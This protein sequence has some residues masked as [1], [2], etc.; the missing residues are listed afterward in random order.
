MTEVNTILQSGHQHIIGIS[1]SRF[2][3]TQ[4]H[5]GHESAPWKVAT[6]LQLSFLLYHMRGSLI[7]SFVAF[8]LYLDSDS[9]GSLSHYLLYCPYTEEIR[10][11]YVPK[12]IVDNP[13]AARPAGNEA[14]LM[15]SILDPE[16]SR[17]PEEIRY[18]WE[19]ITRIYFLSRDYVYNVHNKFEKFYDVKSWRMNSEQW[20][21]IYLT[22]VNMLLTEMPFVNFA[23]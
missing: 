3:F 13:K 21:L 18:N 9:I 12:F 17:L 8:A 4:L 20:D 6:K 15:M 2:L 16:S 5:S 23:L 19:S 1:G 7:L 14:A 11:K 10:Q 22:R